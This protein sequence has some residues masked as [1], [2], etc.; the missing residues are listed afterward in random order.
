MKAILL[1]A[2]RGTRISRMIEDVPKSTL[3]IAG[4]PLIRRTAQMLLDYG[5]ELVVCVGYQA[6]K[7]YK[8]LEGLPVQ[9][10]TNPFYDVTNSIASLWFA[11]NEL[12]GDAVVLNADVYFSKDILNL[13]LN[14]KREVSMAIDKTRTEIGDYFFST[15]DNGCIE[16]YG[17]ELPLTSRSCE[18]VGLAKIESSFMPIFTERLEELV[19]SHKHSLW[20]ENV[21]YSFADTKEQNIY[22]VDVK[23]EFWAEIDYFDDYERILKHIEKEEKVRILKRIKRE[24]EVRV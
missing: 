16:K 19:E 12:Q 23:G 11:R 2:G 24:E 13:V 18:Y 17:K 3:P 5:F 9:Y 14:D 15:T 22:T 6:N 21:L 8:A 7:I 20:W 10:Y 1:A 4:V